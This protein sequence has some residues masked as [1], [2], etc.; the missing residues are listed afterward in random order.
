[1]LCRNPFVKEGIGH[2]CGQ[3]LPCRIN[4]RRT[5]AFR[6]MAE[7]QLHE[8]NSFLNLT[9]SDEK[10]P[11]DYGLDYRHLRLFLGRLRDRVAPQRFRF[12]GC[13]EYETTGE[14]RWNPHFHVALFGFPPCV[15]GRSSFG[16]VSGKCCYF[17]DLV[18]DTWGN[19]HVVLGTLTWSSAHY[20]AQYV[21]KKATKDAYDRPPGCESP[22]ARMSMRPGIAAG[23]AKALAQGLLQAGFSKA[24]IDVPEAVR[25]GSRVMPLGRYLRQKLR[26]ELGRDEK[27][28]KVALAEWQAKMLGLRARAARLASDVGGS[29]A[30]E[31]KIFSEL[32]KAEHAGAANS[33][34]ARFKIQ[35]S[36]GKK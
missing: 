29:A 27:T 33:K 18:R 13:G 26:I 34:I 5:W 12:Y 36:R 20:I 30:L 14:R 11:S 35:Q 17:C 21:T 10:V 22:A 9:Y 3:C 6:I 1:M 32:L 23:Y 15:K 19:G 7:A 8:N 31:K 16:K 24:Q 2:G 28:P 25:D 4:H